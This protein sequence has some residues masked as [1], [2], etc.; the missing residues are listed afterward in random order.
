MLAFACLGSVLLLALVWRTTAF[1]LPGKLWAWAFLNF[2]FF[3]PREYENFLW[4]VQLEPLT[5]GVALI[6][7]MLI[8]ISELR[9]LWKIMANSAL[10]LLA[11]YSF[12]H[13]MLL[14]LLA[15]PITPGRRLAATQS[16]DTNPA[17][18]Y[19]FYALCGI[20]SVGFYFH[21]Y[22]HPPQHPPFA[23]SITQAVPLLRF[24]LSWLG[25]LFVI[26][27][28]D[29]FFFGCFFLATFAA[30]VIAA[31]RVGSWN[32]N[33]WRFYPWIA[34]AAYPLLTGTI[35]APGRMHFGINSATPS[36]Y[37]VVVVF[38]YIGLAGLAAS[39]YD[40]W[41]S[42][43]HRTG[44]R[45]PFA[46]GLTLGLFIA[47]WL[48]SFTTELSRVSVVHEE[49]KDLALAVQWIPV[50]PLNPDLALAKVPPEVITEKALALSNYDAVRPRLIPQSV[51]SAVRQ[52]PAQGDPQIG[53]LGLARFGDD[54]RLLLTG[55]A[56]LPWRNARTDCIVVGYTN[57]DGGLKPFT[58]FRPR[59]TLK[60]QL[61]IKRLQPNGFAASIDAANLPK[62]MLTL[63]AWAV[64]MRAK[65]AFPMAGAITVDNE[66]I[67]RN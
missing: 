4:A 55:T 12:A 60:G 37:A 18:W 35:V 58:V 16:R 47:G 40:V 29:P 62:G 26:P 43:S 1:P 67:Q 6:A 20:L 15:I 33:F 3:C 54:R 30:L 65:R 32:G 28:S 7:A 66:R 23:V 9:L 39:L 57:S 10:A 24:L 21:H 49:R 41:G 2:V 17:C 11:T 50:I 5:P 19:G 45:L 48:S 14:W 44:S 56:W 38:F 31:R 46:S 64:D 52:N 61:D 59:A 25:S 13:G 8:N 42:A 63:R 53:T 22:V 27:G 36:R 51:A 34:I